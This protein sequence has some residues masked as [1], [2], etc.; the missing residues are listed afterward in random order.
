MR[1]AKGWNPW[2]IAILYVK[3]DSFA[4]EFPKSGYIGIVD[5]NKLLD[6]FVVNTRFKGKANLTHIGKEANEESL[7]IEKAVM[8]DTHKQAI[9][10]FM[11]G[12]V[13]GFQGNPT[14]ISELGPLC[15]ALASRELRRMFDLPDDMAKLRRQ[16]SQKWHSTFV[17]IYHEHRCQWWTR[18]LASKP[19]NHVPPND[20]Y[21]LAGEEAGIGAEAS[22]N[23][24]IADRKA[25]T[26]HVMSSWCL[27]TDHWSLKREGYWN[28]DRPPKPTSIRDFDFQWIGTSISTG[29]IAHDERHRTKLPKH[30]K[31]DATGEN[32]AESAAR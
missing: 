2:R 16:L 6:L 21:G 23:G 3:G 18:W 12:M 29:L 30:R 25:S 14:A 17:Q 11:L 19:K 4:V 26:C 28:I 13:F 10:R 8:H 9:A 22:T 20:I 31:R 27:H 7:C 15:L 24:S 1:S 32:A 5:E